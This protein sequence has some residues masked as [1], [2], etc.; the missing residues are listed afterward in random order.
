LRTIVI[1]CTVFMAF[2]AT[3]LKAEKKARPVG[4]FILGEA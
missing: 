1:L 2:A 3:G 4:V